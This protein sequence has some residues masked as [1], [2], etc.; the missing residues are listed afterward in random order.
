[1]RVL[2]YRAILIYLLFLHKEGINASINSPS[3]PAPSKGPVTNDGDSYGVYKQRVMNNN[4]R[5]FDEM[6]DS[7]MELP[8]GTLQ[9]EN[10]HGQ[11]SNNNLNSL[12]TLD[13]AGQFD[14]HLSSPSVVVE[15]D[16]RHLNRRRNDEVEGLYNSKI[17]TTPLFKWGKTFPSKNIV[18]FPHVHV[19]G[20]YDFKTVW[21]GLTRLGIGMSW[22]ATTNRRN[23]KKRGQTSWSANISAGKGLLSP[24]DYA[25]DAELAFPMTKNLFEDNSMSPLQ[26][27]QMQ[28]PTSIALRYETINRNHENRMT[29]TLTA[30]TSFL[31][32]RIQIIGRS[33]FKLG[34]SAAGHSPFSR[35]RQPPSSLASLSSS[36]FLSRIQQRKFQL[37]DELS[38]VPD[39]KMTPGGKVVSNSSFGLFPIDKKG[40]DSST[41]NRVGIRLTVKKQINW[42]IL[43]LFQQQQQQM[44]SMSYDNEDEGEGYNNNDTGVRLEVCGVTGVNSYTSFSVEATL[45]RPRQSIHCALLQEGVI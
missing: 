31:H 45:E 23:Q 3:S 18:S 29:A 39:I 5:S 7:T 13:L 16:N 42:N 36:P 26:Q 25:L 35:L 30:K 32:P 4:E 22:G 34:E 12:V 2:S 40:V 43:G 38:W 6:Q 21:Y 28:P 15:S 19:G 33:I 10:N 9:R 27:M 44:L 24:N 1:M 17:T 37:S 11:K 20:K 8:R 14:I 41:N